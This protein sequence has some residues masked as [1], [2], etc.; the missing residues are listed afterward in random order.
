M[1][2]SATLDSL[3]H[4][5]RIPAAVLL[6][7]ALPLQ[8]FSGL[9]CCQRGGESC[10][11]KIAQSSENFGQSCC[12]KPVTA[13][14]CPNCVAAEEKLQRQQ[15]GKE[16]CR[17][18]S[19]SAPVEQPLKPTSWQLAVTESLSEC[20]LTFTSARSDTSTLPTQTR[21]YEKA[22]LRV[23]AMNSVWLI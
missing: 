17:C 7:L 5:R 8:G 6:I 21:G 22:P 2:L 4:R 11:S 10:C 12:A 14:L 20:S 15:T 3:M 9:R 23:H 1:T 18:R 13:P 16:D 19:H